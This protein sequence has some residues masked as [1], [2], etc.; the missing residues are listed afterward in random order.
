MHWIYFSPH[1][2]DA[3]LSCGGLIWEQSQAEETVEIW[4]ICAG[5]P[6]PG[7][8]TPFAEALHQR[9]GMS[10]E[11]AGLRRLEDLESCS[12][13]CA[14]PRH[15]PLPDCIYRRSELDEAPLY[16]SEES[17]FGPLHPEEGTLVGALAARLVL[18]LPPEAELVS[19]LAIGNHVDHQLTRRALER[20]RRRLWYYADFPYAMKETALFTEMAQ[21]GWLTRL[22]LLSEAALLAWG[23][24]VA[25]HRSQMS[26]FWADEERMRAELGDFSRSQGGMRLWQPPKP[27]RSWR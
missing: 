11:A 6:P 1:I 9:W 13:L 3:A 5:D 12:R 22:F 25:A 26:T 18:Q 19:P 14:Y 7:P 20:I 4:T 8:L 27:G 15:F 21:S 17:L 2:D 24:A 16:P 10:R 23:D